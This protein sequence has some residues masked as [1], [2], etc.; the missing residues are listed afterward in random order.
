MSTWT[1]TESNL[2][3]DDGPMNH[4]FLDENIRVGRLFPVLKIK[5]KKGKGTDKSGISR[6]GF[7][8]VLLNQ[9]AKN[10]NN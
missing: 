2:K 1:L 6:Q 5:R 7:L 9:D 8:F 4:Q 3:L 10:T